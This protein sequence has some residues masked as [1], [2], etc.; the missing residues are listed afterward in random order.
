MDLLGLQAHLPS[1][2]RW[3]AGRACPRLARRLISES[4]YLLAHT[5][6]SRFSPASRYVAPCAI[7]RSAITFL[8]VCRVPG[9]PSDQ[10]FPHPPFS[11]TM[12][13]LLTFS[14]VTFNVGGATSGRLLKVQPRGRSA[15][16]HSSIPALVKVGDQLPDLEVLAENSPDRRRCRERGRSAWAS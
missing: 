16:F 5:Y 13:R 12:L 7:E 1:W 4:N 10:L 9:D 8:F 6:E 11:L 14:R 3:R 15:A 2:L